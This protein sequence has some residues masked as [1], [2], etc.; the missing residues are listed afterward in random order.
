MEETMK[1]I[2]TILK[3]LGVIALVA[4]AGGCAS[5]KSK[6]STLVAAGFKIITP[7]TPAQEAKL[8]A[9]PTDKVTLIQKD[10]KPYY[11]FP[12]KAHH[13][14]YIGGP[15]QFQAYQSLCAE[16]KIASENLEAAR[17]NE[18]SAVGWDTWGGWGGIGAAP[19]W[20]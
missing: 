11:L 9:L 7:S 14:A 4:W 2:Q 12:D 20:Y 18:D 13:Q 3:S 16:Q 5:T 19:G 17:L 15:K 8:Q 10:G 6:E 1:Q